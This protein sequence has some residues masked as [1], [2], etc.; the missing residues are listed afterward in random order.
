MQLHPW[1][2]LDPGLRWGDQ[3]FE[4]FQTPNALFGEHHQPFPP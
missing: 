2:G 1:N 3:L 4:I